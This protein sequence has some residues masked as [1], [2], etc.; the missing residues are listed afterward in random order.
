MRHLPFAIPFEQCEYVGSSSIGTRQLAGPVLDFQMNKSD[1]LNDL[2]ARESW[3]DIRSGAVCGDTLELMFY[4]AAIFNSLTA[5]GPN[6]TTYRYR[7]S[8]TIGSPDSR[9]GDVR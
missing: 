2:D 3:I 4:R 6:S 7:D 1:A 5:L 8:G 9:K